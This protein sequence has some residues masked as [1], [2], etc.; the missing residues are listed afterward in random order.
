MPVQLL[1]V[2]KTLYFS[3]SPEIFQLQSNK[4]YYIRLL[5]NGT[6]ANVL[7]DGMIFDH[8]YIREHFISFTKTLVESF[9]NAI[10][11]EDTTEL[12]NFYNLCNRFIEPLSQLLA[13]K[14]KIQNK[15][16]TD[17]EKFSHFDAN[18]NQIIFKN[19]CEEYKEYKT[20]DESE[21]MSILKGINDIISNCF[22]NKI[23]EKNK[24]KGTDKGIKFFYIPI[25]FIKKKLYKNQILK[26][27]GLNRKK[28]WQM[29]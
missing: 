26:V 13:K 22:K 19:Y 25:P 28:K 20:Y 18:N 10:S 9:F 6:L 14:V 16:K 24:E 2:L 5:T 17:T 15:P 3:Y 4:D 27:I 12:K 7:K 1:D 11:I 29:I 23:Q 21:V 8:F